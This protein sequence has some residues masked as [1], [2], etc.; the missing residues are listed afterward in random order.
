VLASWCLAVTLLSGVAAA[1]VLAR[2]ADVP[3][4]GQGPGAEADPGPGADPD[5]GL[6]C[7]SGSPG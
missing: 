4:P 6:N 5:D 3:R 1:Q 7:S 2:A